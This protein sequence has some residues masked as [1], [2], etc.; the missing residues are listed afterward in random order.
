MADGHA[1]TVA[2][3]LL[4]VEG[5]LVVEDAVV[6][7]NTL[8]VS[9]GDASTGVKDGNSHLVV[10]HRKR[11]FDAPS[12]PGIFESIGDQVAEN[13]RQ[14]FRVA[15]PDKAFG[16]LSLIGDM[17]SVGHLQKRPGNAFSH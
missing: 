7:E 9:L 15:V 11:H 17:V 5:F 6:V 2:A 16:N 12:L 10:L 1:D 3:R 14:G 13:T 8:L 4:S